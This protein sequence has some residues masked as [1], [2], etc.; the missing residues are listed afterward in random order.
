M[1]RTQELLAAR[2]IDGAEQFFTRG[3]DFGYSKNPTET[4]AN[5]DKE[6]ILGD[7]V[8]VIRKFQPDIIICR[9]PTTGEGGHGHHT[10]S[11]ILAEEAFKAAGDPAKYPGQLSLGVKPWQARRLLWN[12]FN[13]GSTN[14][15]REDQL[16]IDVGGYN[17][18][19]GKS[20]GEI[21]AES[22]SMHKSQGFGVPKTRGSQFEYFKSIQGEKPEKNL[23]DGVSTSWERIGAAGIGRDINEIIKNYSFNDPTLSVKPLVNLY[24]KIANLP[25]GLLERSKIKRG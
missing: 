17:F 6:K 9:F 12:T 10:A 16:K 15:Q 2:R 22:R 8:W 11:A 4:F 1:I 25:E 14:T 3:Y 23:L 19:L 20:Y 24:R 13:F 18:L 7:V 21:A 5:W